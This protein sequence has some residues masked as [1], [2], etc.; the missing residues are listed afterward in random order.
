MT[1]SPNEQLDKWSASWPLGIGILSLICLVFGIGLWSMTTK[2]AG[3]VIASGMIQ[4]EA[5]RQVV[6]HLEGGVVGQI[7]V[8]DGDKVDAGDIL[9]RFDDSRLKSELAIIES[10]YFELLA[11]KA[12]FEAERDDRDT[13]QN[14][15]ELIAQSKINTDIRALMDGQTNF[16]MARRISLA[17]Q[18]EQLAEQKIQLGRQVEGV[19]AQIT[20]NKTQLSLIKEELVAAQ[21]LFEKGLA[22]ASRALALRREEARIAGEIGRL[23]SDH[24]RLK[25]GINE[26]DIQLTQLDIQRRE[27]A[28][29]SLRDIIYRILELSE[30]RASL[31]QTLSHLDVRAPMAGLVYGNQIFA[32]QS[33]VQAAEPMMYIIPNDLPLVVQAQVDVVH[34]DQVYIGQDATLNFASFNQRTTPQLFGTVTKISA[35]VFTDQVTGA[36]YYQVELMPKKGEVTK[37]GDLELLPGMPVEAFLNTKER[38]TFTYLVKPIT[39]YFNKAFREE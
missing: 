14:T 13:L 21:E 18:K 37:L 35:D 19:D 9:L 8:K 4:V 38:S 29:E 10:Q 27:I 26:T 15:A 6:Q 20:A 31:L 34:V 5:N 1:I 3:A 39:D 28:I 2:I 30:R 11:R 7:N 24:G 36:N 33:V 25:A 22:V 32:L 12:L 23:I 16:F 17:N